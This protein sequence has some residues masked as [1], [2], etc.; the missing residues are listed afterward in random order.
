MPI[1]RMR[2]AIL[3]IAYW[4]CEVLNFD[5]WKVKTFIA[6]ARGKLSAPA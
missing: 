4:I 5:R 2:F 3:T 1:M 6:I